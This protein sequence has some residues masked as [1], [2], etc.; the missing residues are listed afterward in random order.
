MQQR[1]AKQVLRQLRARGWTGG[2]VTTLRKGVFD[3]AITA[4]DG[5]PCVF[6]TVDDVRLKIKLLNDHPARPGS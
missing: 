2:E 5:E 1:I 4:P 3:I 6:A